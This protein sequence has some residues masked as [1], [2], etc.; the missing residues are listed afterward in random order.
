MVISV[1]NNFNSFN[2]VVLFQNESRYE[3]VQS[4]K[5]KSENTG[6]VSDIYTKNQQLTDQVKF[7]KLEVERFKNTAE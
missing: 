5:I 3:F 6:S 4:G 1:F 7:L 2:K